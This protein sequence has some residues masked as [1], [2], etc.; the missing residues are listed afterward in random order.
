VKARL[1]TDDHDWKQ[2]GC[3][4]CKLKRRACGLEEG[5]TMLPATGMILDLFTGMKSGQTPRRTDVKRR[6]TRKAP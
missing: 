4:H 6:R 1:T 3:E 2:C 5:L